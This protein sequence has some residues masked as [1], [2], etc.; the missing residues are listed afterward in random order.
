MTRSVHFHLLFVATV[1]A[2]AIAAVTDKNATKNDGTCSTHKDCT[3]EG[4][5]CVNDLRSN[6]SF[7]ARAEIFLKEGLKCVN[8]CLLG[9][10]SAECVDC[11]K[12]AMNA[13]LKPCK[14]ECISTAFLMEHGLGHAAIRHHGVAPVLCIPGLP[15]GSAG[16][17]L[18]ECT[19]EK[20]CKLVSYAEVC[21]Y[22]SDCMQS[23]MPVSQLKHS[24]DWSV[25]RIPS[26]E[27]SLALTSLSAH[28]DAKSMSFS[29]IIAKTA[30]LLN[31]VGL[32]RLCDVIAS[33][34]YSL[35]DARA[36]L[37]YS[38]SL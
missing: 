7:C 24:F 15:C 33:F 25:Y 11:H 3:V 13:A 26:G 27:N 4:C 12:K 37:H 2:C 1:F 8:S 9:N 20:T 35:Y 18:R 34:P 22:R 38:E 36:A 17:L 16:H 23:Q 5:T 19:S 14:P 31:Q 32:G 30:D 21:E 29:H 6:T 28:P 10:D